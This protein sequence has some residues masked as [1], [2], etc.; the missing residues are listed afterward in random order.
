[1]NGFCIWGRTIKA[2]NLSAL[3]FSIN[4]FIMFHKLKRLGGEEFNDFAD[5]PSPLHPGKKTGRWTR[6]ATSMRP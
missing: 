6:C 5:P 1:M 3:A 4:M 2:L